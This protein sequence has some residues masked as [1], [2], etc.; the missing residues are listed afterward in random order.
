ML[1]VVGA[2]A[3]ACSS[4]GSSRPDAPSVA[5]AANRWQSHGPAEASLP[6]RLPAQDAQQVITVVAPR[7][8]STTATLQ[9]WTHGHDGW[10]KY[11]PAVLAHLGRNGLSRHEREADVTTP[12]G[13]FSLTQAFGRDPN[14]GTRLRYF[15]TT[16]RDWWISQF[17]PLYNT[18]Q[19]CLAHCAFRTGS[20]NAQLYYVTPQYDLAVAID[21]NRFPVVQGAGSGIFL[22]VS[23]NRPTNGCVSVAKPDLVRLMRWLVPADRPRILIDAD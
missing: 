9:A 20:P 22:H 23:A 12:V 11:G 14:P 16:P 6:T 1:V 18:H 5:P 4:S 15:Q 17:G 8:S 2:L 3:S 13:S 10:T 7:L 19:K 21:F